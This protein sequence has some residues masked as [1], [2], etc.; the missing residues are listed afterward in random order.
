LSS[1]RRYFDFKKKEALLMQSRQK[2][3]VFAALV[4]ITLCLFFFSSA[5]GEMRIQLRN[6][7]SISVPINKEDISSIHFDEKTVNNDFVNYALV[8]K[9]GKVTS[10]FTGWSTPRAL[11]IDGIAGP[12]DPSPSSS[13]KDGIAAYSVGSEPFQVDFNQQVKVQRLGIMHKYGG[14]GGARY[15]I[16]R[17]RIVYSDGASQEIK[18]SKTYSMQYVDVTPHITNFVR[19]EPL[20]FYPAS[21]SRWGVI[22][23]EALGITP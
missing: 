2:R 13:S 17:A 5:Y 16:E 20:S 4:M 19:V 3:S 11:I 21:D 1:L 6:G 9:G 23:F 7:L 18:F 8:S 12:D 10:G 14:G 22:E 15:I